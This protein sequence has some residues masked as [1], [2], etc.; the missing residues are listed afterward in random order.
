MEIQAERRGAQMCLKIA[1]IS[2]YISLAL[3]LY[4][5]HAH[6]FLKWQSKW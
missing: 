6:E 2:H 5:V 3:Q 1:G 4:N